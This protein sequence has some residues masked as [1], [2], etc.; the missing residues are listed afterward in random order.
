ME[1]EP[2]EYKLI[3]IYYE[4]IYN[5]KTKKVNNQHILFDEQEFNNNHGFSLKIEKIIMMA[6]IIIYV[7]KLVLIL[8]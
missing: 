5:G 6:E 3:D 1:N 2:K 7:L 4:I 8:W